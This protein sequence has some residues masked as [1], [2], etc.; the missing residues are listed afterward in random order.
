MARRLTG[1]VAIVTGASRGIGEAIALLFA[2]E[3]ASVV[4][5]ARTRPA[6]ETI[7][8]RIEKQGGAAA[9]L[10][11]GARCSGDGTSNGTCLLASVCLARV[12]RLAIVASGAR[13]PRAIS[14]VVR[15]PSRRRVSAI[16]AS[17][18]STG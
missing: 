7:A 13:N 16:R 18:D 9:V 6:L 5:V 14:S 17:V 3:G 12:I 15:P 11:R 1:K 10:R 2:R 4:L 8:H